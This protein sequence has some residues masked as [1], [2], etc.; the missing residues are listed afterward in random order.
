MDLKGLTKE[1]LQALGLNEQQIEAILGAATANSK[2]GGLPFPLLKINFDMDFGKVGAW[3]YNPQKDDDGT[4]T[5]YEK[6]YDPT[7]KV[8]FLKS[9]YQYSKYD[10]AE[11]KPTITSNIFEL[12]DAKKAY[13]LKTGTLISQLKDMDD[14]IKFQRILLG[15]I[16]DGDERK[17]FILYAKGSFL[18]E[19]NDILRKF[20]N[21][22]HLT[23]IL[24][25][26]TKKNKKGT[27]VWF[28]P[29]LVNSEELDQAEFLKRVKEDA[30]LISKFNEWVEQVNSGGENDN[31]TTQTQVD[32]MEEDEDNIEF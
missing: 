13:D 22:A 17:P 19:L 11:G 10:S 24:E 29:T 6:I 18:F 5:G 2:T 8:R 25:L 26:G 14:G 23:H 21:D 32:D 7:I 31:S 1:Q 3:A 20:P 30:E 9:M 15:V 28:T 16:E 27:V 12:K 4:I